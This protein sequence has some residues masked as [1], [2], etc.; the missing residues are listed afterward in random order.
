MGEGD[1]RVK[2]QISPASACTSLLDTG[3]LLKLTIPSCISLSEKPQNDSSS[4]SAW[5][6]LANSLATSGLGFCKNPQWLNASRTSP[7][8]KPQEDYQSPHKKH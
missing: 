2:E 4:E 5:K 8:G 6:M 1:V 7:F 3:E